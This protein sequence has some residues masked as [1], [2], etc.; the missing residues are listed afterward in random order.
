MNQTVHIPWIMDGEPLPHLMKGQDI[1]LLL[2]LCRLQR[3]EL[4]APAR[5]PSAGSLPAVPLA[6][7]GDTHE[8]SL[9]SDAFSLRSLSSRTGLSKSEVSLA[10]K[11]CIDSGLA[12]QDLASG[13]VKPVQRNL[14]EFLVHGLKYVFP[15]RL[16]PVARGVPTA[17]AAPVMAGKVMSAGDLIPVWP[18]GLGQHK[19]QSVEPLYKT[20]PQAARQD[21]A[22]YDLLALVDGIRIG[23]AREA[24]IAAELLKER[25]SS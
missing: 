14:L 24:G 17:F 25:L 19:G 16:G 21:E 13:Q 10:L 4:Q 20:V 23:N 1:L 3:S 9:I 18:D 6:A 7:E 5:Q 12:R 11:R 8:R 22:L 2:T 15:A